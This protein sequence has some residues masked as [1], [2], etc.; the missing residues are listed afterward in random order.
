MPAYATPD[1]TRRGAGT[2]RAEDPDGERG[3]G[4]LGADEVEHEGRGPGSSGTSVSAGWSGLPS[5]T[6]SRTSRT[7][8]GTAF[9]ASCTGSE[10]SSS[11]S[12]RS[13]SCFVKRRFV[14]Q[15]VVPDLP[16]PETL[17]LA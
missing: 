9:T 11:G 13:A 10:I 1:S 15:S 6:P 16:R 4:S 8:C 3:V 12:A 14:T 2:R 5:Q 7:G 17:T